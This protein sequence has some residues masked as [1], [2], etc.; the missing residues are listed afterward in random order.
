MQPP[1]GPP[2]RDTSY[3]RP[4]QKSPQK[5]EVERESLKRQGKGGMR[6]R[7]AQEKNVIGSEFL[8]IFN[9]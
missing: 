5:N 1:R 3:D 4:N 8:R 6:E 7:I 2:S 9:I